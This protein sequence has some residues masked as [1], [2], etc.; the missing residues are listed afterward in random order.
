MVN[1]LIVGYE[2]EV[3]N[4]VAALKYRGIS[5][6][7]ATELS[8][9]AQYERLLLPGGDDICPALFGEESNGTRKTDENLDRRQ[10]AILDAF[11]KAKKPVLGICKGHQV[12][13]VYFGGTIIQDLP[14]NVDHQHNVVDQTHEVT[15]VPGSKLFALCGERCTVNSS[16]HQGLKFVP[17]C[18]TITQKA[19]DGVIEGIEHVSLPILGVQWHPERIAYTKNT[20]PYMDGGKIIDYFLSM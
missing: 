18:F 9:I 1:V 13:N 11:V 19:P 4:Y 17:D 8:D 10:L 12:L 2:K 15:S 20:P 5:Y 16:H 6:E 7:I 3:P 14:T